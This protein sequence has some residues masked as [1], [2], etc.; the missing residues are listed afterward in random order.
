MPTAYCHNCGLTWTPRTEHPRSCPRCH[1][2]RWEGKGESFGDSW[3]FEVLNMLDEEGT[4][5]VDTLL[6]LNNRPKNLYR[7][8]YEDV[9]RHLIDQ[10]WV[11]VKGDYCRIT[12]AG[13]EKVAKAA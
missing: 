4:S 7:Q 10:G 3:D 13:K 9:L 6:V 11:T 8:R 1:S 5:D 12:R 2:Y